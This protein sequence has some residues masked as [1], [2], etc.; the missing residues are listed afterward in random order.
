MKDRSEAFKEW[1]TA[2]RLFLLWGVTLLSSRNVRNINQPLCEDGI[3]MWKDE[4]CYAWKWYE[5]GRYDDLD[6]R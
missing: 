1:R 6:S 4:L 5:E 2:V 3:S